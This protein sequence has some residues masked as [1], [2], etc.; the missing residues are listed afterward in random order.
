MENYPF[1]VQIIEAKF[2]KQL[3]STKNEASAVNAGADGGVDKFHDEI[4]DVS[5]GKGANDTRDACRHR[6]QDERCTTT[7]T[8]QKKNWTNNETER[9]RWKINKRK[10]IMLTY[11]IYN[12]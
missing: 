11:R 2:V 9:A 6:S 4:H 10:K 7:K 5:I 12:Q 8:G 3:N 1:E